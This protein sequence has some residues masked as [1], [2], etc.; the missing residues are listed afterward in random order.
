M[1]LEI[2][3][4]GPWEVLAD[5]EPAVLTGK[6]RVAV[7]T[8]LALNAG[9]TVSA[10]RLRGQ[11]WG[12]S[13]A[14]TAGKQ[15]HIVVS[16]L[17]EALLPEVIVTVPGGYRLDLPR[18]SVDVHRFTQLTRQARAAHRRGDLAAADRLYHQALGLW[19]G[20]ALAGMTD[21][22]AQA[23]SARLETEHLAAVEEHVDVRLAAGQHHEVV[24]ALTA[25]VEAH[26]LRERPRAQLMLALYRAS[27]TSEAL[28]V[29]RETRRALSD[30]LGIEPGPALR[31]LHQAVLHRDP[32]LDLPRRRVPPAGPAGPA[33]PRPAAG[34]PGHPPGRVVPAELPPD[35]R[36]FIG[37]TAEAACLRDT[38]TFAQPGLPAVAAVHGP[39]GVG[40]STLAIH[41]AHAVADLFTDG[42]I[43]VDLRAT[44][45][46]VGPYE[47]LCRLLRS[48]GL[49]GAAVPPALEEAAA[50]YRSLT[51]ARN[52]LVVLDN[53]LDADQVRPL[54]PAGTRCAVI[55]TSRRM[56]A[57]LD[58]AS[59]LRLTALDTGTRE[60]ARDTGWC[61][62]KRLACRHADILTPQRV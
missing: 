62:V 40:K 48:L 35:V 33:L 14:T 34:A 36:T 53:A 23:E 1:G 11:I 43:Y 56:P 25:H 15:L 27:R 54:I 49:D 37:R 60:P 6:R 19:R 13:A 55:V 21:A 58:S 9:H 61:V 45:R 51:S 26:P 39:R 2:N 28:E 16:K 52:L 3:V 46:S 29:Y 12:D 31:R 22:W 38:L 5:G 17:R 59:H 4:L 50:R 42:V 57:T 44:T 10:E 18:E 24:S 20:D 8:Q 41:V 47:V 30:E 32:A 7:L